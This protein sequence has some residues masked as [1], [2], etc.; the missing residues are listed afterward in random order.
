MPKITLKQNYRKRDRFVNSNINTDNFNLRGKTNSGKG[1]SK[2]ILTILK[3]SFPST[4]MLDDLIKR[5]TNSKPKLLPNAFIAY[6]MALMKEYRIKN[7]KL[8]PMGEVSKIAKN[9]WNIEPKHVK[10]FYESLV[11]DAKAIYKQNNIQIILDKH[12][13]NHVVNS[14]END[15]TYN[16]VVN[17]DSQIQNPFDVENSNKSSFLSVDSTSIGDQEYINVLEQIIYC[18]L[19]N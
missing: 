7:C 13:G 15:A 10:D 3:P 18:L 9:S 11:E 1:D 2:N 17:E 8:P 14:Q 19:K 6:R 4:L 5:N 12:M 16:A